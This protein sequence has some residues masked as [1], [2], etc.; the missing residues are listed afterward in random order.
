MSE[1]ER[2]SEGEKEIET[3][4]R[5]EKKEERK[6]NIRLKGEMYSTLIKKKNKFPYI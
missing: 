3:G 5:G 4:S 6:G 2:G 1:K